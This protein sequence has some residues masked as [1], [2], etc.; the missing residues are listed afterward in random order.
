MADPDKSTSKFLSL[1]LRHEPQRIGLTL[2]SHG[3]ADVEEL[4]AKSAFHKVPLTLEGLKRIVATSDKQRFVFS[5]DGTRIRANQG[6]SIKVDLQLEEKVPPEELYHG[7]A[8]KNIDS[9]KTKGILRGER[10]HVHLS[11]DGATARKVGERHGDPVVIAVKARLMNDQGYTFY[12]SANGVWLTD[13]V[14][15]QYLDL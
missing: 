13:R 6:H 4:L 7:T 14:P 3:W 5:D 9:I 11:G 15:P 12:L 8:R 1:I 10:H 2:D